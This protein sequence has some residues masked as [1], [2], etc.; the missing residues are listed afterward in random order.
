MGQ[1]SIQPS[2]PSAEG[3][4]TCKISF[5][6]CSMMPMCARMLL[7]LICRERSSHMI[8]KLAVTDL[9]SNIALCQKHWPRKLSL[10]VQNKQLKD[11]NGRRCQYRKTPGAD[12]HLAWNR[13]SITSS[14]SSTIKGSSNSIPP[15]LAP[16]A[17]PSQPGCCSRFC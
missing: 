9:Q 16:Q 2:L 7:S 13:Y 11:H 5:V 10:S 1:K 14:S 4:L 17:A 8:Q 12:G 6:R 3:G 15:G